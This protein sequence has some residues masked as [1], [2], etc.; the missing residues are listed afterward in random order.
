[1][2][3]LLCAKGFDPDTGGD[4]PRY[5][6]VRAYAGVVVD[7][8]RVAALRAGGHS[9]R[10]IARL[11]STSVASVQRALKRRPVSPTAYLDVPAGVADD[12]E[13]SVVEFGPTDGYQVCDPFTYVGCERVPVDM[14]RLE[15]PASTVVARWVDGKGWSCDDADIYARQ[16]HVKH[17]LG[18]PKRAAAIRADWESQLIAA[19]WWRPT[20]PGVY[21]LRP[22]KGV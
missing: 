15:E 17:E 8:E 14:G 13:G 20:G 9:F 6:L 1:M 3:N 2:G 11:L 7:A 4:T 12:D 5:S 22:P 10:E 21:A 19:G 18:D 16:Q